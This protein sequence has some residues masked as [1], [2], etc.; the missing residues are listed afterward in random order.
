MTDM[1]LLSFLL[2]QRIHETELVRVTLE[3][4]ATLVFSLLNLN[5]PSYD[6]KWLLIFLS[7]SWCS[8]CS[9]LS[10][11]LAGRHLT[12]SVCGWTVV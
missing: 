2:E 11:Y 10:K 5:F 6:V 3:L 12:S 7:F 8:L 1:H 9:V 4:T